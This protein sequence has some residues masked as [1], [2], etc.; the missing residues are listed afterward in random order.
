MKVYFLLFRAKRTLFSEIYTHGM[1]LVPA[2][3]ACGRLFE[4]RRNGVS[5][6]SASSVRPER[7]SSVVRYVFGKRRA[8]FWTVTLEKNSIQ[9]RASQHP[10]YF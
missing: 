3:L 9:K 8:R 5:E 10:V 4:L 1:E 6:N 7:D 2:S